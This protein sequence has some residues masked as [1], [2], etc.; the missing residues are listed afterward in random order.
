MMAASS[1]SSNLSDHLAQDDL[2]PW[3]SSSSS[4]LPFA[5]A[6]PHH[7][8]IIGGNSQQ[9]LALN[10]ADRHHSDELEVLLSAQGSHHH[11]SHS[12]RHSHPA[13]PVI[14]PQLSSSL[15]TMQDLGFQWSNC[16]G[17]FLDT[18]P[19]TPPTNGQLQHDGHDDDKIEAEGTLITNSSRPSCAGTATIAAS[20]HDVVLHGGGGGGTVL[21]TIN[22]SLTTTTTTHTQAQQQQRPFLA[23]PPPLPGDAFEILLASSRLCKTLLLSQA[24]ASSSSSSVLLH[25]DGTI[26]TVPSLRSESEHVAYGYGGGPP[27]PAPAAAHRPRGRRPSVDNYKQQMGAAACAAG[28]GRQWSAEHG[29]RAAACEERAAAAPA[30][31]P[32]VVPWK[33]PRLEQR[34]GSGSGSGSS[35]TILPSFETDTASVLMEAIGYIKFLQDQVETLSRP[36]LKS[37][38]SS[39]KPR[40]THQRGCWNASAAGEEQEQEETTT[41]RRRPDL[42][43]RGLCLV[44]L[45]CTSYVTNEN[46]AWVPSQF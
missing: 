16:G 6:A 7:S 37:S 24:A 26:S 35:T 31:R 28:A 4:S 21:P 17:G 18:S 14:P 5:P 15:L 30:R 25:D 29:G 44:P 39:K 1:S 13:S 33:K 40:P 8:A 3:P 11:Q 23:A 20:C 46:G 34:S 9:P 32:V 27:P 43:S 45:S 36:Y 41:R 22:I 38:R 10:C 2:L 19:S 12:H 42:R